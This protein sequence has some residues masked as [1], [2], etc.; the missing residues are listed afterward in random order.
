SASNPESLNVSNSA[1]AIKYA[2]DH[3]AKIINYSAGGPEFSEDEYRAIKEAELRGVLF[4]SA[5]GNDHQNTDQVENYYYPAAYRLSN[6]I[7]VAAT[8]IH[9]NLLSSS[10]WGKKRVDVAAPGESI[11]STL[12]NG[13]FGYMTGT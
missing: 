1:K 7:A 12:P 9:N 11:Y 5:A 2:V 10:N 13:R 3:G 8:D 4:V 6:I